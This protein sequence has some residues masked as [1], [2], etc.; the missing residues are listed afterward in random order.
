MLKNMELYADYDDYTLISK[1]K[2]AQHQLSTYAK[3]LIGEFNGNTYS[4]YYYI[5]YDMLISDIYTFLKSYIAEHSKVPFSTYYTI[6]IRENKSAI[7]LIPIKKHAPFDASGLD[8][9]LKTLDNPKLVYDI[10]RGDSRYYDHILCLEDFEKFKA[11]KEESPMYFKEYIKE[12][13]DAI[14]N[15]TP[16]LTLADVFKR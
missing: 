1:L 15:M 11:A 6:S 8:K 10:A 14:D 13:L 3:E 12:I 5:A 4:S 9:A 7:M 2:N 16:S